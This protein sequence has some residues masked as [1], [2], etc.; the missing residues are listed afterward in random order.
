M[1]EMDLSR[2]KRTNEEDEENHS[3]A[4]ILRA[5]EEYLVLKG[6]SK[7]TVEAYCQDVWGYMRF[8]RQR[9]GEE[10][11]DMA[12]FNRGDLLR[13]YQHQTAEARVSPATWNRR[14]AS[15]RVFA[16]WAIGE[17]LLNYDPTDG[18]PVAESVE[19]APL[20]LGGRELGRLERAIER[21][22]IAARTPAQRSK[23]VRDRAIVLLMLKGGLREGEVCGLNVGDVTLGERKGRISVRFGKG[24]KCRVVPV[25]SQALTALRQWLA[26]RP[27]AGEALFV[28]K[29]GRRLQARG[30]QRMVAELG[31]QAGIDDLTPHRLRHSCA[32]CLLDAGVKL[33]EVAKLLGHGGL[34]TTLRYVQPSEKDL[35]TA[36]EK[37]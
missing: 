1:F 15:L 36:V 28:G 37:I 23:A 12:M 17:G 22:I 11:F 7:N 35:E 5:F 25:N 31:R 20:W 34:N 13:F 24:N 19:L 16:Q 26:L 33:S 10:I 27:G 32:K 30:I 8:A 4:V 9:Y 6:R 14:R 2:H 21:G 18:L 3:A 29:G